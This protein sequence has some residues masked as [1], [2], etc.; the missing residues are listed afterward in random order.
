MRRALLPLL[1]L[2][3]GSL[4]ALEVFPP[5]P[6]SHTGVRI[7][8]TAIRCAPVPQV[9]VTGF[10]IRLTSMST[11]N[12]ACIL[13]TIESPVVA[14]VGI[15]RPGVYSVESES[16]EHGTLI[17][18]DAGA[19]VVVS[20]V[21]IS[22]VITPRVARTVQVFSDTLLVPP[23]SVLFDGVAAKIEAG[24]AAIPRQL[25]VTPPAHD[26]GTIDVTVTDAN[27]TRK[28]IA[29]FTYFDP[30]A[31][32][33]PQLF[34]PVLYPAAYNGPGVFGSQWRTENGVA[35]GNTILRF[36]EVEKVEA[37]NGTCGNLNWSGLVSRQS[38]AGALVWMVRRRLPAGFD[39]QLRLSSR[40]IEFGHPDDVN[41][42][43]PVARENDFKQSFAIERIPLGDGGRVTLRLYATS[44]TA[45]SA[46]VLADRAGEITAYVVPLK[47]VGGLAFGSIDLLPSPLHP[48]TSPLTVR[49]TSSE[50]VWGLATV[51]DNATQRVTAFWP[52]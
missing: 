8:F 51:T 4:F 3:H 38:P 2:A 48:R 12:V 15:L 33:D 49:V 9:T 14:D 16:N 27:G 39:D 17:V 31:P 41:T 28:A 47:P 36:R 10:T 7:E 34:E 50:K 24:D 40:I 30:A 5:A 35:T 42:T 44:T 26:P 43:L 19:G 6:D 1:L 37:C 18:R 29:A 13:A 21:G 52:Q 45:Q 11:P 25:L 32:P 20:P 23:L 46:T 22:S